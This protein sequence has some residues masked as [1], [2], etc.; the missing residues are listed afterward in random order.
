[1]RLHDDRTVASIA[2]PD[3][4]VLDKDVLAKDGRIHGGEV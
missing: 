4:D 3:E 2:R 1:M